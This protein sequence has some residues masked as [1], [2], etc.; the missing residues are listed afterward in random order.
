MAPP[1]TQSLLLFRREKKN[2]HLKVPGSVKGWLRFFQCP[3][4]RVNP[5]VLCV[6]V[7]MILLWFSHES[8]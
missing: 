7:G 2:L 1:R 8:A 6:C 3:G 4:L 5:R